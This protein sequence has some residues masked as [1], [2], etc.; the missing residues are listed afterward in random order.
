MDKRIRDRIKRI[1]KLEVE[2]L[3]DEAIIAEKKE[4]MILVEAVQSELLRRVVMLSAFV[5]MLAISTVGFLGNPRPLN[6]LTILVSVMLIIAALVQ[7]TQK[8]KVLMDLYKAADKLY[9]SE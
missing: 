9:I 6:L 5:I 3:S 4:V 8:Y 7:Y 2:L 1:E